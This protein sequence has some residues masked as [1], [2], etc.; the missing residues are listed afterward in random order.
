MTTY[1]GR[2]KLGI[3][4]SCFSQLC[5]KAQTLAQMNCK[6]EAEVVN[7][8]TDYFS[9]SS[10][11]KT[12]SDENEKLVLQLHE[13]QASRNIEKPKFATKLLANRIAH[14]VLGQ[15]IAYPIRI[16]SSTYVFQIYIPQSPE[17]VVS[18]IYR[19]SHKYNLD[20]SHYLDRLS[21]L[22]KVILTR[23]PVGSA[24]Q[25]YPY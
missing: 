18:N 14:P 9:S 15:P 22:R 3:I 10:K 2:D 11:T 17:S 8:Q 21:S 20:F 23:L 13:A 24:S 19:A 7:L 12:D 25:D 6:L 1:L 5:H 4:S 16:F